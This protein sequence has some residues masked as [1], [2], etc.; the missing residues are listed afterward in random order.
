M[1]KPTKAQRAVL[2]VMAGGE[3]LSSSGSHYWF[4]GR[5]DIKILWAVG[6]SLYTPHHWIA[7]KPQTA[8]QPYWRTE[9]E[10]TPAGREAIK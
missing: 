9:F 7:E 3:R 8:Q 6:Y 4:Q 5:L 1:K 2:E 10:I